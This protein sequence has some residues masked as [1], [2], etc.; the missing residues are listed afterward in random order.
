M[1]R[2]ILYFHRK[3]GDGLNLVLPHKL[4]QVAIHL[5]HDLPT[6]GH[7]EV[8]R[9]THRIKE[10]FF[11]YGMGN[12]IERYILGCEVCNK[13]KKASRNVK[14]PMVVHHA[15][16]PMERVHIDFLGPLPKTKQGNEHI[17]MMV[18]QFTKWV[19]IIPLSSQTAEETA[20]AAVNCFF[21]RFGVPFRI[22]SDQGRNFESKLFTSLCE[23]LQIHKQRT[24]PYRP[25]SNGQVER[26]NRTL[27]D[28][29]RCFI[30]KNQHTWDVFI[31]QLAA[32]LRSAVNRNTGFT[33]NKMMLG[34]EVNLPAD[35]MFSSAQDKQQVDPESYVSQLG[36]TITKDT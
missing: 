4:R 18:D 35:L 25:S 36:D 22:F 13:C 17:L 14:F 12:D 15:G 23:V 3:H 24:T 33:A 26:Y 10:K 8:S 27:M 30:D 21:S 29:V 19:E 16:A 11:W 6:A 31:P 32:A 7:Q 20:R 34:R 28:A 5:N 9:T 1:H 2:G